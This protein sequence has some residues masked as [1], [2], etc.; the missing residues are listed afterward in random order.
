MALRLAAT[1]RVLGP[2]R[3]NAC[4]IVTYHRVSPDVVDDD[5]MLNVHPTRFR[6]QIEG[7]LAL[8]YQ[9]VPLSR[10]VELHQSGQP[11]PR[12]SFCVVFD[13]GYD[14]IYR[15]A[16]PVLHRY[17]VPATIF[18]ATAYLDS[19]D[20][21]PF[22][23]WSGAARSRPLSTDECLEMQASG[24][25]ELGSHTH[26]HWDF[27]GHDEAFR[28]DLQCSVATLHDRF[29][30]ASPTFSFPYGFHDPALTAAAREAGVVCGLTAECGL[31]DPLSDPF[32]WGRFGGTDLDTPRT[33]AAKLDGW[34]TA[35]RDLY[36]R[37][38]GGFRKDR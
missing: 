32:S 16:W 10:L 1:L 35:S 37:A 33:L 13:D 23:A 18:L 36:R 14:D 2:R 31:A 7:L 38:R 26:R 29:G 11:F 12:R 28:V 19:A 22:D 6:E 30:V 3:G 20:P 21:F 9:A 15:H 34:Y 24:L 5:A 17:R 25:I 8:G 27:R 4:G